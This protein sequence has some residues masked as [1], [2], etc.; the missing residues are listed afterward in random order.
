MFLRL[1]FH[2]VSVYEWQ[3]RSEKEKR[4]ADSIDTII[5]GFSEHKVD[6]E[7][8]AF[9][10]AKPFDEIM[11]NKFWPVSGEADQEAIFKQHCSGIKLAPTAIF[12]HVKPAMLKR[13]SKDIASSGIEAGEPWFSNQDK[14]PRKEKLNTFYKALCECGDLQSID[15]LLTENIHIY[16]FRPFLKSNVLLW[17]ELLQKYARIDGGGTRLRP[18]LIKAY[19]NDNTI[20]FAMAHA[21]KDL[22]PTLSQFVSFC[23]YYPDNDMCTRGNS[24]IYMNQ[25]P[26]RGSDG[27][28]PNINMSLLESVSIMLG[29]NKRETARSF[30]FYVYAILCSQVYLDEFEGA[31]F[32]VNQSDKRARV[33]IVKDKETFD[34]IV[35]YG[36]RL[37]ELEKI[38]YEPENILGYDYDSLIEKIPSG[39]KLS[40]SI[41]PFDEENESLV[42]TDGR[43]KIK[44]YCPVELQHLNISGYDV[45]KS[46]W[47]KFNS[48]NFTHCEF[49]KADMKALLDF[50]NTIEM[51]S[52]IVAELDDEVRSILH[53]DTDLLIP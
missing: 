53:G 20:G 49:T 46:V 24:H 32:T 33:P 14:P 45:I 34:K 8:F 27:F 26:T 37:A 51:H 15:Q 13:R 28:E 43:D 40:N 10:P 2:P 50:L 42:L 38:D 19:S 25:Y 21:P 12:T 3:R 48:Y 31:L 1:R 39:F 52:K 4:L 36:I 44:V 7:T 41:H 16:S 9:Y 17:T 22:N 30:V 23:W 18:E 29:K 11:Y 6:Q 47:L 5:S 35:E